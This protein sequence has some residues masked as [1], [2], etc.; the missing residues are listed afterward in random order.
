MNINTF[1]KI[2]KLEDLPQPDGVYILHFSQK[3]QHCGHYVGYST[4][5]VQRM[6]QHRTKTDGVGLILELFRQG[7]TFEP[8]LFFP[9]ADMDFEYFI[10]RKYKGTPKLCP[11]C[12][13]NGWKP[14]PISE[15]HKKKKKSKIFTPE[16]ETIIQPDTELFIF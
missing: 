3:V 4:N 14:T 8:V 13:R 12:Q 5:I 7:G 15:I 9:G 16:L 1:P 10:K 11:I 2:Y 6:K